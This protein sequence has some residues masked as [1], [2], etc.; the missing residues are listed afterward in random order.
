MVHEKVPSTKDIL[1][2][3]QESWNS[4][5]KRYCF[6]LMKSMPERIKVVI[7]AEG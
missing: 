7:K 2:T 6:E 3:V 4:F 5:D 1:T